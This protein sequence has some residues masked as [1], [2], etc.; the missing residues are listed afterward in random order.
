MTNGVGDDGLATVVTTHAHRDHWQGLAEVVAATGATT[1]AHEADA[2]D[3]DVTPQAV[4]DA[5]D[6]SENPADSGHPTKHKKK[7]QQVTGG[8]LGSY[9]QGYAANQ[10]EDLGASC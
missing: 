3:I 1:I 10:S 7:N 4:S 6:R 5:I 2:P 8:S 9:Q